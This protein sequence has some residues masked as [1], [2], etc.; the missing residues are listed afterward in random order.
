[1]KV[2][3]A[4]LLILWLIFAFTSESYA[5]RN[6]IMYRPFDWQVI[7]SE[8]LRYAIYFTKG[9][10]DVA[11]LAREDI[12]QMIPF[13]ANYA[14]VSEWPVIDTSSKT[15]RLEPYVGIFPGS[16]EKDSTKKI[17][18]EKKSW[19]PRELVILL[20]PGP[21]F[22]QQQII[23]SF[24][25]PGIGG[26]TE[27]QKKRV[28]V[29]WNGDKHFFRIVLAHEVTHAFVTHYLAERKIANARLG[30]PFQNENE[31]IPLWFEEGLA[32]FMAVQFLGL[33]PSDSRL[34]QHQEYTLLNIRNGSI[35]T[36]ARYEDFVN[37][38]PDFYVYALGYQLVKHALSD[39][40]KTLPILLDNSIAYKDFKKAWHST[41]GKILEETYNE[42]YDI[43][44][45]RSIKSTLLSPADESFS[46][47]VSL[48]NPAVKKHF[49]L[50]ALNYDPISEIIVGYE[51]DEKW[52]V[53]IVAIVQGKQIEIARQFERKS[54]FFK[55]YSPPAIIGRTVAIVLHKGG[56]DKIQIYDIVGDENPE[57]RP[58][59]IIDL[60][61]FLDNPILSIED[62]YFANADVLFFTG[63]D[64][65]GF[66]NIY[67]YDNAH[68]MVWRHTKNI[69]GKRNPLLVSITKDYNVAYIGVLENGREKLCFSDSN[70]YAVSIGD[71]SYAIARV[72]VRENTIYLHIINTDGTSDILIW[73]P[74]NNH[75]HRYRYGVKDLSGLSGS[76]FVRSRLIEQLI[77]VSSKKELIVALN[78]Q[79]DIHPQTR[80]VKISVDT[81]K[82]EKLPV[83]ISKIAEEKTTL[84]DT[85]GISGQIK[86]VKPFFL[87]SF[88]VEG[89]KND[90]VTFK[91]PTGEQNLFA[92]L[93]FYHSETF[94]FLGYGVFYYE[95]R[96]K[97][98]SKGLL[99]EGGKYFN[100][101]LPLW[102]WNSSASF[103][104][105]FE[106]NGVLNWPL[107]LEQAVGGII[108]IGYL[109]RSYI[110]AKQ[111]SFSSPTLKTAVYLTDDA[112]FPD[113][114]RGSNHGHWYRLKIYDTFAVPEKKFSILDGAI[115]TDLRYYL[116]P[117]SNNAHFAF[118]IHAGKN[119]G[120]D[121]YAF[122]DTDLHR[123]P[124][125]GWYRFDWTKSIGENILTYQVEYRLPFTR[126]IFAD[127]N[128]F[129]KRKIDLIAPIISIIPT[130][131]IYGGDINWNKQPIHF[132]HR[133]GIAIKIGFLI[134]YF[135]LRYEYYRFA[136]SALWREAA[137]IGIDY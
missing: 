99:I 51:Y 94:G 135:H 8:N 68:R 5:Q 43:N 58:R 56:A 41:F 113:Y 101:R 54:L 110:F 134:P 130:L 111:K 38:A 77:G 125:F 107:N 48:F 13:Y 80:F 103:D 106:I 17:I 36:L 120:K 133:Y 82:L 47:P 55:V 53:K 115:E 60:P 57:A 46:D 121:P 129:N 49:L 109:D 32:E 104:K 9:M 23:D 137:V 118:R 132:T 30:N 45:T 124:G 62:L 14:F 64:T 42:W 25:P 34:I 33:T 15:Y 100:S 24:I 127:Y 86:K 19:Y 126:V 71:E 69:S 108:G 4:I 136:N 2:I 26:F 3:K 52:G 131:F 116:R 59:E 123:L 102:I 96:A 63:A 117:W 93:T 72:L 105:T 92:R 44:L 7:E 70:N 73:N 40:A 65:N 29:P 75:A 76:K 1:M 84:S 74:K 27:L 89:A 88:F 112:S 28:A 12:E 6:R 66:K 114:M 39:N 37:Q 50:G 83:A 81:T 79:P 122:V 61:N 11:A 21:D 95:N 67:A 10:E 22:N 78:Y 20:Y 85:L 97:R 90:G 18:T 91:N 31:I 128:F 87:S 35:L 119:F 98:L 16:V